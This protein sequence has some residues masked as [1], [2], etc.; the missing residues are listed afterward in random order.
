MMTVVGEALV[1]VLVRPDGSRSERPG[2]GPANVALALARLDHSV[3]L[4]TTLG[5]DDRGHRV[6][7]HLRASG[8]RV[9]AAPAARTSTAT[10]T[11]DASGSA[12]YAFDVSWDPGRLALPRGGLL[13]VGSLGAFLEPGADA[14][15]RLVLAARG[16]AVVSLDP[17]LRPSLLADRAAVVARLERL[18]ALADVVKASDEDLRW[19]YPGDDPEDAA[20]AWL[21]LGPRLVV[22]TAG[23]EGAVALTADV[24]V[25]LRAPETTVVD[26]VGAGDTFMAGLLSRLDDEGLLDPDD[27]DRLAALDP[28]TLQRV[29]GTAVRAAAVVVG[30]EGADPPRREELGP[31]LG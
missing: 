1:D 14:V 8:V 24:R 21:A 3:T 27:R 10:A 15:E 31:A 9:E 4:L 20:R 2:G 17:N 13:H 5:D 16:A 22:V 7:E 26:T 18:V 23:G 11:L 6:A 29:L 25:E 30:R 28:A 12:S 19:A